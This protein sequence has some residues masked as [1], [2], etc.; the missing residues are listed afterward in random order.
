MVITKMYP[1]IWWILAPD[2]A[3]IRPLGVRP[4]FQPPHKRASERVSEFVCVCMCVCVGRS[5]TKETERTHGQKLL[6]FRTIRAAILDQKQTVDGYTDARR[7]LIDSPAPETPLPGKRKPDGVGCWQRTRRSEL[8]ARLA[9]WKLGCGC[10]V[11]RLQKPSHGYSSD[12]LAVKIR[13][14]RAGSK[15]SS[16]AHHLCLSAGSPESGLQQWGV[17]QWSHFAAYGQGEASQWWV[18][19]TPKFLSPWEDYNFPNPQPYMWLWRARPR[20]SGRWAARARRPTTR[21]ISN[22]YTHAPM[23]SITP[24]SGPESTYTSSPSGF[25][26]TVPVPARVRTAI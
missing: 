26:R 9:V 19:S 18:Q 10:S 23:C 6:H 14:T 3:S 22:I 5:E 11:L 1:S 16:H 20:F 21:A 17:H 13:L 8:S 4:P 24:S 2:L 12:E 7:Q 25:R 15:C